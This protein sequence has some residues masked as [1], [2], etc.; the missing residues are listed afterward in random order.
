MSHVEVEAS[1]RQ[2]VGF[3]KSQRGGHVLR[4]PVSGAAGN[5]AIH[6]RVVPRGAPYLVVYPFVKKRE[7]YTLSIEDRRRAMHEH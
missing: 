7:W 1:L 3:E 6:R 5:H 4:Q 2:I